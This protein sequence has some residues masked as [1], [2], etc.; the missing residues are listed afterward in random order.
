MTLYMP[1]FRSCTTLRTL[2]QLHAHLFVTRLHEDPLASTKLIESYAQMGYLQSSRLVFETFPNPDSFMWGVLIKCHVWNHFFQES[3]SL[4]HKMLYHQ[5]QVNRFIYPSILRACSGFG[6]LGI[7]GKVHGRIIK[8]GFDTDAIAETALLS[9]YGEMGCLD[10]ARKIFDGM[11]IKDVVL[12]S[13]IISCYVENGEASEGVD[14]FHGM[15]S[16]GVEPDSVTMLSVA[17]ACGDLGLLRLARSVHGQVVT[18][19]IRS[20][21]FL[22]TYLIIMYS[23]C[24]DLHSAEMIFQNV[25]HRNTVCWTAMITCYNQVNCFREAMDVFVEMQGFKVEPNA[26]TI[27]CIICSCARLGLLREGKSVHCFVI[28]KALA[29][30]IEFLGPA[31]IELYAECGKLNY[32]EEVLHALGQKNIVSWNMLISLFAHKGLLRKA[33]E[34]FVQIQMQG[35]MPDSYSLS[36]SLSACGNM[37]SIQLGYQIHSHVIKRGILDEFVQNS[38]IDMYCK[39]GDV[40]SGYMIFEKIKQLSVVTWNSMICGFSQNG[41]SVE[42]IRLFDQMYL[43]GIEMNEVTFLS[44]IQACSHLGHLEKGK[45]VHHKLITCGLK[46]DYYVDTALTDMYAKSGDLQAAQGIFDSMSE[47][48]VVSWSAMIDGYGIHGQI[49]AAIS[50]FNRMVDSGIKPNK[51]TFMNILSA[52]SHVGSVEKGR[53]YFS[54]MRNFGIE[55]NTEH[56]SVVVDLLSRSGDLNEAYEIIKSMPLPVDASIWGA[57]LNGC[58]IHQRMDMIKSIKRDLRDISTDDT[59]YYTLLSNIYAEGGDWNEVRKVRSMME[60][61]GLTKVPGWSSIELEKTIYRFGA[62]DSS[63]LQTYEIYRVLKNFPTLDSEP[64]YN[65]ENDS[66]IA[67]FS[68]GR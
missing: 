46:M 15:V 41:N 51:V 60:G 35:L 49:D 43:N 42:A 6:D 14:L 5:V 61:I 40:C 62:G 23:K 32:C 38:L 66:S 67:N 36:S 18:R 64:R 68:Q 8:F 24:G 30:D 33:L 28:K 2:T 21:G 57:L 31:L 55:P 34:L 11:H 50:L 65:V 4:Y 59:G 27:M 22:D 52:C 3:I 29:A 48:S 44:V 26:V 17:E 47:R 53:F 7:G 63:H 56:F 54:L 12:W 39:C 10:D 37:G 1:L 45:W 25:T 16:Q 13:S 19:A 20:D 58:R 9:M